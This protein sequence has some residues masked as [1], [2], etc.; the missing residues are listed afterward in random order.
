MGGRIFHCA[1][2]AFCCWPRLSSNVRPHKLNLRVLEAADAA[3]FLK[4]R[5]VGLQESPSAFGSSY[6][7]ESDRTIEQVQNHLTG[8]DER[9]FYGVW[10]E[11]KLVGIVG[12]GREQGAKERHVA[13]VR[14]MYVAPCARGQGLGR[15]ILGAALEQAFSWQGVEHVSLAVTASNEAALCLYKSVGFVQVGRMP[16]ALRVGTEYFDE[17]NMV[18]F[19]GVA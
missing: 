16:R 7:E 10:Q 15:Q 14:S 11:G 6:D 19:A 18:C 13:F 4:V 1:G 12:V 9:V 17:L 8:S 2:L 5:L 3:P